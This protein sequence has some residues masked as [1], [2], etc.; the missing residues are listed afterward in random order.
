[1][2]ESTPKDLSVA[3]PITA[4][5]CRAHKKDGS[6]CGLYPIR[7]A[8]VC[9]V[10]GGGA[11]QVRRKAEDRLRALEAP[12]I[13]RL[14]ELMRQSDSPSV[15]IAAVKDVLDRVRGRATERVEVG[16]ELG[17]R[18]VVEHIHQ[19]ALPAADTR[20]LPPHI[21]EDTT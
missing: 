11:P 8:A 14:E 9:R 1:M 4:A 2:A 6:P 5:K 16:G 3:G 10:H 7:G 17:L 21:D 20:V 13:H 12:A 19:P 18:T 15:A